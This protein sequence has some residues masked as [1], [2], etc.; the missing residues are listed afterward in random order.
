MQS[1][2]LEKMMDKPHFRPGVS[3]PPALPHNGR[4][5]RKYTQKLNQNLRLVFGTRPS[6]HIASLINQQSVPGSHTGAI[7]RALGAAGKDHIRSLAPKMMGAWQ[8][9]VRRTNEPWMPSSW[10]G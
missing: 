9:T 1:V 6:P 3:G 5:Q 8:D 4:W 7:Q 10:G 2:S